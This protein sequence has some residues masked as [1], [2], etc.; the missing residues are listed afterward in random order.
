MSYLRYLVRAADG[1]EKRGR[2]A[3][4]IQLGRLAALIKLNSGSEFG[5]DHG[6]EGVV[7][8]KDFAERIPVTDYE[9]YRPYVER[10]AE[11][12]SGALLGREEKLQMFAL[13]S[14]TT[15]QPK[16]I[17]VGGTF[18]RNYRRGWK[19]IASLVYRDHPE[20]WHRQ[21]FQLASP[22]NDYL[23]SGG[24][25]CGAISGLTEQMQNWLARRYY[26]V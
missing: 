11:G 23:T 16:Q 2:R 20:V 3:K 12:N 25:P 10:M 1:L 8:Y 26:A 15:G 14:G 22:A 13:T 19:K 21:I 7:A 24:I 5:Q 9:S 6:L 17:P 4:E 18:F